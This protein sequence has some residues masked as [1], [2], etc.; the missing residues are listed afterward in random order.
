M[1]IQ[2]QMYQELLKE[3]AVHITE[4]LYGHPFK[5]EHSGKADNEVSLYGGLDQEI[6]YSSTNT[7][8]SWQIFQKTDLD[9]FLEWLHRQFRGY[10][11]GI[12]GTII[13][14]MME[15]NP[16]D[17]YEKCWDLHQIYLS[18][19]TLNGSMIASQSFFQIVDEYNMQRGLGVK[20]VLRVPVISL[21]QPLGDIASTLDALAPPGAVSLLDESV[22]RKGV[23]VRP[24]TSVKFHPDLGELR[25]FVMGRQMV[26]LSGTAHPP[27][28]G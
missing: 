1:N 28:K 9:N 6:Y 13:G 5:A 23:M 2:Q 24:A 12:K 7:H 22:Q 18:D 11:V 27:P 19:I 25:L 3:E 26:E 15:G 16:Y 4:V 17:L 20:E 14:W 21:W 8:L 10:R